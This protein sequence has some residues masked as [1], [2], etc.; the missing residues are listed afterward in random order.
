ML[1]KT[2][3]TLASF[4]VTVL[5]TL[6]VVVALYVSLGRYY[7]PMLNTYQNEIV[8]ELK[9]L[10]GLNFEIAQLHGEWRRFSPTIR[11]EDFQLLD[12]AGNET[13]FRVGNLYVA[14]DFIE[15]LKTLSPQF[16]NIEFR[17]VEVH[18]QET[19]PRV[20]KTRRMIAISTDLKLCFG[21]RTRLVAQV[22]LFSPF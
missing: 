14:F 13:S 20:L 16:T 21:R 11:M 5:V 6:L 17:N 1:V 15:S 12:E 18:L 2:V 22:S 9:S 10:S 4:V 3:D 7:V 19:E 8:A